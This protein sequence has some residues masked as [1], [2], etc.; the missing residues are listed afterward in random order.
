[1]SRWPGKYVIGLTGNIATGKSVVRK[2]LEH[3]G[4]YGIDADALSHRAIAPGAPGYQKVLDTFGKWILTPEGEIDRAKLGRVVFPD[5]EAMATLEAIIHP[6]VRQAIDI[7]VERTQSPVIVI[8]AIKLLEGELKSWCDAIWVTH[9]SPELQLER[10]TTR[11]QLSAEEAK[12]R[13]AAQGDPQ[14]KIDA[15]DVVIFNEATFEKTW[16]QVLEAWKRTVPRMKAAPQAAATGAAGEL[17][18]RRAGPAQAEAIARFISRVSNG[19]RAMTRMDVMAAFGEK[20]YLLLMNGDEIVGVL[21]WQVENLVARV[22]DLL[23]DERA[24]LEEGLSLL[25]S[26]VEEAATELL[27]EAL[28]VFLP[29]ELARHHTLWE[30]MGY[31]PRTVKELGVSAWQE[32]AMESMPSGTVLFFKQ[33]RK[34]RVLRPV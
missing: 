8:E 3:L 16:E 2:M 27:S 29:P 31:A 28:L 25:M 9:A 1:M 21:G 18:V 22:D 24:P 14:A 30:K 6:L 5:P 7:L 32:A 26:T 12:A 34:D 11:R 13:I 23:L 10:L 20:G 4:A 33:L 19:R 15:A 17:H